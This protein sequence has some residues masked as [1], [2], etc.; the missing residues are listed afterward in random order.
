MQTSPESAVSGENPNTRLEAFCDGVFS[1]ALTLLII[2]IAIPSTKTINNTADF[3]SALRGI[4]PS[5]WAFL[6]SFTIVF[7]LWVNHHAT[8]KLINKSSVHF[9]YANGIFLL[10]AVF[11]PFPTS[12]LG[13]YILTD[14]SSPA[15]VLY[16]SVCVLQA[17]GWFLLTLTALNP[18]RLLTKNDAATLTMHV[19]HKYSYYSI[20]FYGIC[21]IVAFWLPQPVAIVISASWLVWLI[22]GITISESGD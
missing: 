1:V 15:V 11:I 2:D 13:K 8:L 20:A 21:V 6:L 4:A 3:W 14:H 10:S 5:L 22:R 12:L 17:I 16:G 9:I 19:N 18:T 7:I